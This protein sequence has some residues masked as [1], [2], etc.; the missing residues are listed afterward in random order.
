M[1]WLTKNVHQ[2]LRSFFGTFQLSS[3]LVLRLPKVHA[4]S[5]ARLLAKSPNILYR[6]LPPLSFLCLR[7]AIKQITWFKVLTKL[8]NKNIPN[9]S[10]IPNQKFK[11]Q[12][13]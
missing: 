2:E 11:Y 1:H 4:Y 10:Y 9:F 3:S 8:S 13:L 7:F 6:A 12:E 5:H